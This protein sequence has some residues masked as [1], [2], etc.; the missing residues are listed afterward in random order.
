MNMFHATVTTSRTRNTVLPLD[1]TFMG[2][3]IVKVCLSTINVM[4][5][6]TIFFI[7]FSAVHVS[8]GFSAHRA[9][10]LYLQHRVL[11]KLVWCDR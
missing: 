4:K 6:Y 8:S 10:K 9:Q 1:L 3:C 11:V 5:R 7:V 2:P